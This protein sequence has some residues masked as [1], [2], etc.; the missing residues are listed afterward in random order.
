[1]TDL[2]PSAIA[3]QP[4]LEVRDLCTVFDTPAGQVRAVDGVSFTLGARRRLGVV[5]ESGSGKSVAAMSILRLIDTP[6]RI[7][8][9]EILFRGR[10]L[11]GLSDHQFLALRG[12]DLCLVFQ[13]PMSALN[14]VYRVGR[15]V[16]EQILAHRRVS[17]AALRAEVVE[18]FRQVGIPDPDQRFD[19]YPHNL[20]GGM[21]Q[22]VVIAM[23]MANK[24]DLL[25]LD[26]PTTALDVTIQAQI[27]DVIRGLTETTVMLITHDFGVVREICDEVVVMYAGSV[28][29]QGPMEEVTARPRHPY[30]R[31]LLASMPGLAQRGQPL[32][33]IPG[34]VPSPFDMPPGCRF[35]PRCEHAMARCASRP[36]LFAAGTDH[37]SACW[38]QET[39]TDV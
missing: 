4:V 28:M 11:R 22:R 30:T 34:T 18:L 7:E 5:G 39:P 3:A 2:A 10:D 27:L 6:G 19:E 16:G 32:F 33:A 23:A 14:P 29:E 24:P 38:L 13:D 1:M 35:A 9:G 37:L 31:A 15:Q 12:R 25:I 21:R 17:K 8:S 20:S 26:E 36:P